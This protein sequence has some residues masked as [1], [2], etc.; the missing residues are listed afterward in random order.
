MTI[1]GA[2]RPA[3]ESKKAK[4]VSIQVCLQKYKD[5]SKQHWLNKKVWNFYRPNGQSN[6]KLYRLVAGAIRHIHERSK[7]HLT[8]QPK[9]N[10]ASFWKQVSLQCWLHQPANPQPPKQ[11]DGYTTWKC[12]DV[13]TILQKIWHHNIHEPSRIVRQHGRMNSDWHESRAGVHGLT[14]GPMHR[15]VRGQWTGAWVN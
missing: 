10:L 1:N 5:R 7:L 8:Q 14:S 2:A 11:I 3:R 9:L 6:K 13:K 12:S 4:K 15:S